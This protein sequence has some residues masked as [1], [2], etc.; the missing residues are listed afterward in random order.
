MDIRVN[1]FMVLAMLSSC[2]SLGFA[3]TQYDESTL[4]ETNVNDA[5]II[6]DR[7]LK[8]NIKVSV[9]ENVSITA[10]SLSVYGENSSLV[11]LGGNKVNAGNISIFKGANINAYRT[12]INANKIFLEEEGASLFLKDC[13]ATLKKEISLFNESNI[14]IDSSF[15]QADFIKYASSYQG[16]G[17]D[18]KIINGGSLNLTGKGYNGSSYANIYV[19]S[20]SS[21]S[22]TEKM[23]YNG[24]L[25]FEA[26]AEISF[27]KGNDI[28]N[29][30]FEFVVDDI[31]PFQDKELNEYFETITLAG[32]SIENLL[33]TENLTVYDKSTNMT[34]NI[35]ISDNGAITII[36]EPSTCAAILGAIALAFATYIRRK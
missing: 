7:Y 33:T 15:L 17:G 28:S 22:T 19:D 8:G 25:S 10:N 13:T 3:N 29:M 24:K 14:V 36:P 23:Q 4:V 5:Q 27:A 35:R 34:Y 21:F 20:T 1:K 32:S 9:G 16:G 2:I 12:T 31:S 18:I 30:T 26:G 6:V 11:F